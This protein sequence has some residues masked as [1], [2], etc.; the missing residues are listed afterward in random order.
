VSFPADASALRILEPAAGTGAFILP[1]IPHLVAAV[2]GVG[3]PLASLGK[4]VT[5]C[6]IDAEVSATLKANCTRELIKCGVEKPTATRVAR[7]WVK[8]VDFLNADLEPGYTHIIGNPPYIRWDAIPK[9]IIA[10]YR[11][12]FQSFKARADLYV[13]FIERSLEL[14]AEDGQLG[15]LCPNTWTRTVYG[16]YVRSA[17]TTTG[18]LKSI[19]D[20]TDAESFERSADAYPSFFVFKKGG[21]GATKLM[22][23]KEIVDGKHL[24]SV[25]V[26]RQFPP[27]ARPLLLGDN[28]TVKFVER[29]SGMFPKLADADC[30]VRVGSATGC[31]NVFLGS[32]ESFDVEQDR[33]LPFVNARSIVKGSLIWHG[34]AII[35]VFDADGRLIDLKRYPRLC[36]YLSDNEKALRSRAKA[37]N[38]QLWWRT[39]DTLHPEWYSS[40]KLLIT[41][42]TACPV[43]GL[44]TRGYC[45][46]SGVYQVRSR[47]WPL[48]ELL[49]LLSAGVLGAYVSALSQE[50]IKG[51]HRFQKRHLDAIPIPRWDALETAWRT[52]FTQAVSKADLDQ[53]TELVGKIYKCGPELLAANRARDWDALRKYG[54]AETVHGQTMGR[55]SQVNSR[56]R[57][58]K[59]AEGPQSY[60]ASEAW[61]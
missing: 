22:A 25:P 13:V 32:F 9:T 39:I 24:I 21:R 17:L 16:S 28:A 35:N 18:H 20:L 40:P 48:K 8:N 29:I 46:G 12:R 15:F 30:I 10:T 43:I 49:F 55:K 42:I 59:K 47:N 5:A 54:Q 26:E 33:L 14:L 58:G 3:R 2:R 31:N 51:F 11:N 41:D 1:L 38:G 57:R 4:I 6:E 23:A 45:A 36:R 7:Q 19:I 52:E 37:K 27:T 56:S 44:D 61:K 60:R 34:E 53:V 50:T